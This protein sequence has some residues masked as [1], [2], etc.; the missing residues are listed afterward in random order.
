ML[1]DRAEDQE[2]RPVD[3]KLLP[4]VALAQRLE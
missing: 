2:Q 3:A 4:V 1:E